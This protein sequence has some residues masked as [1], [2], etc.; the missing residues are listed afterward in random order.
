[1]NDALIRAHL[2][3]YA[4]LRN[5][6]DLLDL[7]PEAQRIAGGWEIAIQFVVSG[8]GPSAYV[9]FQGGRCRHGVGAH[10]NPTVKLLFLSPNHLNR[11]F[12]GHG[13]PIPLK[14]FGRLGFMARTF[15]KITARLEHFLRPDKV[16]AP[17]ADYRRISTI[18]TLHTAVFAVRELA[19]LEPTSKK[20]AAAVPKG[21]LQVEVL[22]DGPFLN[23]TF[24]KDDVQV[25]KGRVESPGARMT[26]DSLDT[27]SALLGGQLDGFLAV[28]EGKLRLRG[29]LPMVDN[30][31][32]ILDRVEK[33][34]V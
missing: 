29:Q 23:L 14:G 8:G 4:V 34:L 10:P 20:V 32:L 27:A 11:M 18:L 7:D 16:A 26:F 30:T 9:E 17:D 12:A 33:Y 5:L 21:I 13:M 19:L 25:A 22:P 28:A 31:N 1:M 15:P 2:N 6:E 3:L 24:G